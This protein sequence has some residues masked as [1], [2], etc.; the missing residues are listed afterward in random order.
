[1]VDP[2]T[3][4]ACK[5]TEDMDSPIKRL[6][7]A[8]AGS[9]GDNQCT[10]TKPIAWSFPNFMICGDQDVSRVTRWGN[11]V[12][13]HV[14]GY[15]ISGY[16]YG[17]TLFAKKGYAEFGWHPDSLSCF[18]NYDMLQIRVNENA[19]CFCSGQGAVGAGDT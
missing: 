12:S 10:N 4:C 16:L 5:G 3:T 6:I 2:N 1:M 15:G 14:E 17:M 19:S 18:S 11:D 13:W 9:C 7:A 8:L